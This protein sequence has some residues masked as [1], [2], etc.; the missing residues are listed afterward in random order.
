MS[1]LPKVLR[2]MAVIEGATQK[3]TAAE[4]ASYSGA[5]VWMADDEAGALESLRRG[6]TFGALCSAIA[7]GGDPAPAAERAFRLLTTWLNDR[8]IVGS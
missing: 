7:A 1:G 4:G 6:E 8:L 5:N 2:G 3:N